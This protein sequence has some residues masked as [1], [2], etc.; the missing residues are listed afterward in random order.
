MSS[1]WARTRSPFFGSNSI[2]SL[3]G[4]AMS[5][6]KTALVDLPL[7]TK[8]RASVLVSAPTVILAV[9]AN[10]ALRLSRCSRARWRKGWFGAGLGNIGVGSIL[11][12]VICAAVVL[13]FW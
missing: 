3:L 12:M 7:G 1:C 13:Y 8:P 11:W 2:V 10:G 9:T 4:A 5:G 6:M